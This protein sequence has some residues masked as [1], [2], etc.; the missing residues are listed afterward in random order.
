MKIFFVFFLKLLPILCFADPK[1]YLSGD[2]FKSYCD[3]IYDE[4]DK[5]LKP[6]K[7][8]PNSCI[9]VKT[10]YINTFFKQIHHKIPYKYVLITH[11]SDYAT[12]INKT[13][14]HNDD[15]LIV[16]FGQNADI[17]SWKKVHPLPIGLANNMWPHGN[18]KIMDDIRSQSFEKK[19]LA[20]LNIKAFTYGKERNTVTSFFKNKT[21]CYKSSNKKYKEYLIDIAESKFTISPR[22]NG[23]DTHRLWEAL[24]LGSI[25]V[26]KTSVLDS[27]YKDLPVLIINDWNEVTEEYLNE[28]YELMKRKTY[29]L[30]KLNISYWHKIFDKYKYSY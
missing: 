19:H 3:Y 2:N 28:N 21:Y 12:S 23:L 11:N 17:P 18:K 7:V 14:R 20:Y 5:S 10:D 16:W 1:E 13:H 6:K 9:F 29:N 30:D 27:L 8:K 24:Y 22:G 26:V 25:P 4:T 15:K